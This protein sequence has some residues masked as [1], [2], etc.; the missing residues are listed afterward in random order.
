MAARSIGSGTISLALISIPVKLFTAISSKSISFNLLHNAPCK[1]RL[2]QEM[3]CPAHDPPIPIDDRA[4]QTLKGFE[5]A[6]D[7]YVTF[8]NEEVRALE[9]TQTGLIQIEGFTPAGQ[10]GPLR[11]ERSYFLGPDKGGA[12]GYALLARI[13]ALRGDIAFG[14]FAK[15][16]KDCLVAIAPH[17]TGL[18]LHECYYDEEICSFDVN[19]PET[20]P[21]QIELDLANKIV[22]QLWRPEFPHERFHDR[23]AERVRA[24]VERKVAGEEF[25]VPSAAAP[26]AMR[27]LVQ[28]LEMS[29]RPLT[30]GPKKAA[31]RAK[32]DT[33]KRR[34]TEA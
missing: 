24:A 11:V 28:A 7:Q 6:R 1:S 25:V 4:T 30:K 34:S 23:W 26:P 31:P 27:D 9:E 32:S 33:K 17:A 3:H 16:G 22:G 21:R 13:L 20:P 8:T 12:G 15:R 2:K 10:I 19:A 5:Y 14:T 29:L 18:A